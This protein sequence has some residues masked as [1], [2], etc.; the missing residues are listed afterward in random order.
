MPCKNKVLERTLTI[1]ILRK[2]VE[3]EKITAETPPNF[4]FQREM[5]LSPLHRHDLSPD[6]AEAS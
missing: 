5:L 2:I 4:T 6:N 1:Y 3:E